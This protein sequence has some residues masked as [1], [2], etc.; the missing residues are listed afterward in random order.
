MSIKLKHSDIVSAA[1]KREF[2]KKLFDVVA[3]KYNIATIVL[4]FGF[5]KLWKK[6][7]LKNLPDTEAPVCLDIAC[8]TGDISNMLYEKYKGAKINAIDLNNN[9]LKIAKMKNGNINYI[10]SDMNKIDFENEMFDIVSGGYALRN[11][12]DLKTALTEIYR[13]MKYGSS[14][15]FL[16][17]NKTANKFFQ[18]IEMFILRQ[19]GNLWGIILHKNPDI[20]GYIA[21]SLKNYPDKKELVDI[22]KK[23]G[24]KNIKFISLFFGFTSIV[25]FKK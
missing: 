21:E 4:S 12:P 6:K 9:M 8:G 3:P 25:L 20:Y 7:L 5:D 10:L 2:N 18:K 22:L 19:W 17:F 23:T 13:V 14:A 11:A 16:D 1:S 15:A 24:F